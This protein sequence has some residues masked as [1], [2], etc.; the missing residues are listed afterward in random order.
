MSFFI[1]CN[2]EIKPSYEYKLIVGKGF[3][4]LNNVIKLD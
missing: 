2:K 1:L 4:S 3:S